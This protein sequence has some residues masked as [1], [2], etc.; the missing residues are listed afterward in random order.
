MSEDRPIGVFDSGTKGPYP[1][2]L[3][4]YVDGVNLR[5]AM[6][7]GGFTPAE[8]LTLAVGVA[9]VTKGNI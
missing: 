8:A 3:M 2:L 4:E 1:Y 6:R 5:Q 7:A 9:A